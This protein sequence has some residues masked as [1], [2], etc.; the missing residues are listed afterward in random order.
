M[1]QGKTT[2]YRFQYQ[3]LNGKLSGESFEQQTED[4]INDL[5][6]VVY[7]VKEQSTQAGELAQSAMDTARKAQETA[8][9]AESKS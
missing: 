4:V 9:R 1:V 7:E 5:G 6:Q 8:D 3:P 2:K